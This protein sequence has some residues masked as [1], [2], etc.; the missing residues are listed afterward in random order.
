MTDP[1]S[2]YRQAAGRGASSVALLVL[3][4]EQVI[5]DLRRAATAIEQNDIELRTAKINHAVLVIG[6]LQS[7]LNFGAGGQVARNLE[8]F[9]NLLRRRLLEAQVQASKEIVNEQISVLLDLRDAWT[10]VE[11]AEAPR[12]APNPVPST[13]EA[14]GVIAGRATHADW[15]G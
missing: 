15:K 1:K 4:Y 11:R 14:A 6:H 7:K 9:Y 2:A 10:R 3:L 8:R 13:V 12:S 5:E